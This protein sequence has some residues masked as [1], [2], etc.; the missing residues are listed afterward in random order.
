MYQY[1]KIKISVELAKNVGADETEINLTSKNN[2]ALI[3][4][5]FIL[6]ILISLP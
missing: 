2:V 1:L 6:K 3:N 4:N 5:K